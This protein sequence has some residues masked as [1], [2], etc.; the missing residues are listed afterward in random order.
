MNAGGWT[1]LILSWSG[2]IALVVFCFVKIFTKK[3]V[4]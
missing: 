3:K 2:I 1:L 4:D